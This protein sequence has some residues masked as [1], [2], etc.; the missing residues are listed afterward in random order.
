MKT[1]KKIGKFLKNVGLAIVGF[2][3]LTFNYC[4]YVLDG[5]FVALFPRHVISFHVWNNPKR[6]YD[7]D[8]Q[9]KS[10]IRVLILIL[11]ALLWQL[12]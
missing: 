3:T 8:E 9:K 1:L 11:I 6:N 4:I 10:Y 7:H 2:F 12:T 5:L